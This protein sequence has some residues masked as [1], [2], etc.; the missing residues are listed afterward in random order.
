MEIHCKNCGTAITA[1]DGQKTVTC[2][3]CGMQ[4]TLPIMHSDL[5]MKMLFEANADRLASKFDIAKVKY[6][7]LITLYPDDNEAYWCKILCEYGI[8]YVDDALT[9]R[10]IPT[11]HRTVEQSIFDNED[12]KFITSR[13]T[14]EERAIY[15]SEAVEI[16]RIQKEICKV[17]EA[18][19]PY[20]IFICFKDT[21]GEGKRTLDSQYG[22]KIYT[23]LTNNGYKVFFSRVSL[24]DKLGREY[25]PVIY[26]ALKSSKLMLLVCT[27]SEHVNSAWVRNEWS[28]FLEFAEHD[29]EKTVVPCLADMDVY[30]LPD[31]LSRFQVADMKELDFYESLLRQINSKFNRKSS[32]SANG[33]G[34][35][36]NKEE[37]GQKAE[38][39]S[40]MGTAKEFFVKAK[41]KIKDAIVDKATAFVQTKITPQAEKVE[42]ASNYHNAQLYLKSDLTDEDNY[43]K[44]T[45]YLEKAK[46]YKDADDLLILLPTMRAKQMEAKLQRERESCYMK[47]T[48]LLKYDITVDETYNAIVAYLEKAKGYKDAEVLLVEVAVKREKLILAKR[49]KEERVLWCRRNRKVIITVAVLVGIAI[50]TAIIVPLIVNGIIG[51]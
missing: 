18:E 15:E 49:K 22:G 11:C 29:V 48:A 41:G 47:A 16:D 24:K 21:D 1:N 45:E 51:A 25:E 14:A 42:K 28:R 5:Q 38:E 17:A 19:Q 31:T 2:D 40:I 10:K 27:S 4:Q 44:A 39:R 26:S 23:Y 36:P 12:Y 32:E 34:S 3:F 20:D 35:G 33:S 13:A 43:K 50:A 7:R 30:D 46:G 6:D 9:E 37:H 8:E